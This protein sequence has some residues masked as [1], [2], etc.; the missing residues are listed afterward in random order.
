MRDYQQATETPRETDTFIHKKRATGSIM[1]TCFFVMAA[2]TQPVG[3]ISVKKYVS[4][5][6]RNHVFSI[7]VVEYRQNAEITEDFDGLVKQGAS[8]HYPMSSRAIKG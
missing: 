1:A 6:T 3:A 2:N 4:C 5:T 8:P 7:I